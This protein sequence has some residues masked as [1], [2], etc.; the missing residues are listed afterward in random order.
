M[1]SP[2]R[3]G[4]VAAPLTAWRTLGPAEK[5]FVAMLP[6]FGYDEV[7]TCHYLDHDRDWLAKA[8][9]DKP[10]MAQAIADVRTHPGDT[11]Q[12]F[13][14]DLLGLTAFR[15]YEILHLDGEWRLK[16]SAIEHIHRMA[17]LP[18][19]SPKGGKS[20]RSAGT[21]KLIDAGDVPMFPSAAANERDELIRREREAD[22]DAA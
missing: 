11:M 14:R 1:P 13:C 19:T 12:Q 20:G 18:E 16:L 21:T 22:D 9:G 3:P 15:L 2:G 5:L 4:Q 10:M 17:G 8:L 6:W 7:A